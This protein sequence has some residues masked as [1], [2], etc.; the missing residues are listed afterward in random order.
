M[1]QRYRVD[2]PVVGTLSFIL[3]YLMFESIEGFKPQRISL[4]LIDD[5]TSDFLNH[6]HAAFHFLAVMIISDCKCE[7]LNYHFSAKLTKRIVSPR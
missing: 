5:S 7:L 1:R 2:S 6:A 3:V 4:E